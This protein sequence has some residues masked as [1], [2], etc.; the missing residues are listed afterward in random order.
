MKRLM[1][2]DDSAVIRRR[3]SRTH[4]LEHYEV[5]GTAE[6][7]QQAVK[8]A[9][10]LQPDMITID[11]TMPNMEG[12]VAIPLLA[13]LC[14]DARILV[15]S[16]LADKATAIAALASGAQGFLCKPFTDEELTLALQELDRD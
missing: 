5:V 14:P 8:L 6:D 11:L 13:E 12:T 16:A 15:V 4:G 10:E 9:R 7:G 2:V 1:I 3:I